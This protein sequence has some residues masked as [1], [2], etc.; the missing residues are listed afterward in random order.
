M[1]PI[2]TLWKYTGMGFDLVAL[3][4]GKGMRGPQN[5]GILMGKKRLTDLAAANNKSGRWNEYELLTPIETE[6]QIF[7]RGGAVRRVC[8]LNV[9]Y[10]GGNLARHMCL[11]SASV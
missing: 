11:Y 5:A 4:G 6:F 2:G 8:F 9:L 3:S 10:P 1:P 7:W